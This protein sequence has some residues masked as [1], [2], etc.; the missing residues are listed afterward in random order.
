[1]DVL[2]LVGM[3]SICTVEDL[4]KRQI[5]LVVISAFGIVGVLLHFYDGKQTALNMCGGMLVGI[6]LYLISILSHGKV[7]KGDAFLVT[8]M[9]VYLGFWNNLTILWMAAVMAAIFGVVACVFFR[10]EKEES[11]PFV[12]FLL[13][14]YLLFL[15]LGAGTAKAV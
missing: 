6:V 4:W 13:V 1:M 14:A 5:H 3:L 9:G 10:K 15:C 8:S 12:P 7:G 11:L 2:G